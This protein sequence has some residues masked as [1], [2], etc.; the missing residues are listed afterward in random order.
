MGVGGGVDS[1]EMIK[2]STIIK[3]GAMKTV[4]VLSTK[5]NVHFWLSS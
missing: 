3:F 4:N 1:D 2:T 5:A